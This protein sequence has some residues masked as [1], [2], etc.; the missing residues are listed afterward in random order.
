M[1]MSWKKKEIFSMG[2]SEESGHIPSIPVH[3]RP[4]NSLQG[5]TWLSPFTQPPSFT[6]SCSAT[7]SGALSSGLTGVP[8]VPASS[9]F[10]QWTKRVPATGPLHMLLLEFFQYPCG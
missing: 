9:V 6:D 1:D 5:L 2:M 10:L 7:S 4:Q 3:E 8:G